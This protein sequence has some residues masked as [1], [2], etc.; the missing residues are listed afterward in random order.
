MER[1]WSGRTGHFAWRGRSVCTFLQS[2]QV[3]QET[4]GEPATRGQQRGR[5]EVDAGAAGA[6]AARYYSEGRLHGLQEFGRLRRFTSRQPQPED[7][8]Q[9]SEM[10]HDRGTSQQRRKVLRGT[11][12]ST[13]P[14][15]SDTRS[16]AGCQRQGRVKER[17]KARARRHQRCQLLRGRLGPAGIINRKKTQR[18]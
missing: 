1:N 15:Q 7:Q 11:A 10:E 8:I 18:R 16:E 12:E 9:L 14:E 5:K 2:S 6:A 3:D 17:G 13:V 4:D